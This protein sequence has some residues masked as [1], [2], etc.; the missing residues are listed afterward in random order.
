MFGRFLSS[1]ALAAA[2][3]PLAGCSQTTSTEFADESWNGSIAYGSFTDPRDNQAYR[4]VRIGTQTWFA[5]NLNYR[6]PMTSDTGACMNHDPSNCKLYG[7]YYDWAGAMDADTKYNSASLSTSLP[8]Q[9]ACPIGWHL[10]S[11]AEWGVLLAF[12]DS[13]SSGVKL[14]S[15]KYW[16]TA[17]GTDDYGFRILPA[18]WRD[19]TFLGIGLT[20]QFWTSTATG[21]STAWGRADNSDQSG[22]NTASAS[23]RLFLSV[24]CL[25]N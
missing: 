8:R 17:P 24:R 21:S 25:S 20:G 6:R 10:P 23:K 13:G 4:T 7:R 19:G 1:M 2:V 16:T 14:R 12:V 5:Q 3:F 18:G 11:Q 15:R 9:G 22:I